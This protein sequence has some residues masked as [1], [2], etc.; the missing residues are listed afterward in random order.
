M[1]R[2]KTTKTARDLAKTRLPQKNGNELRPT[3][4][5]LLA[6]I[7]TTQEPGPLERAYHTRLVGPLQLQIVRLMTDVRKELASYQTARDELAVKCGAEI[8]RND[9]GSIRYQFTKREK[10]TQKEQQNVDDFT[11]E[12]NALLMQEV[13]LHHPTM[14]A[15]LPSISLDGDELQA[16]EWLVVE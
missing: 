10:P 1:A 2:K 13:V 16:L 9:D 7:G 4:I 14:P 15:L 6:S 12:H 5:Q 11:K 3:I 8:I